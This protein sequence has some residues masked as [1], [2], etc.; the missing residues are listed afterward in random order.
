M[1]IEALSDQDRR[2]LLAVLQRHNLTVES[3]RFCRPVL[4]GRQLR[5]VLKG[6]G[7]CVSPNLA[8]TGNALPKAAAQTCQIRF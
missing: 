5:A 4:H 1:A 8:S 6:F 7:L 2:Q 3:Y